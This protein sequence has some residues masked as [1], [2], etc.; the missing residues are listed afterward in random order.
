MVDLAGIIVFLI[1]T[2]PISL[3][4][5][6]D[7]AMPHGALT[8]T[9]RVLHRQVHMMTADPSQSAQMANLRLE[10]PNLQSSLDF[11]LE[12]RVESEKTT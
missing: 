10:G 6:N 5:M 3:I 1:Y 11:D 9:I 7:Q 8:T 4:Q 2:S 12:R